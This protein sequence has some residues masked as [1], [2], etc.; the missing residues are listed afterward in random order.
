MVHVRTSTVSFVLNWGF[1]VAFLVQRFIEMRNGC[2]LQSLV[3]LVFISFYER[4]GGPVAMPLLVHSWSLEIRAALSSPLLIPHLIGRNPFRLQHWAV[5]F[6]LVAFL[7]WVRFLWP[8]FRIIHQFFF[9]RHFFT[10]IGRFATVCEIL[11]ALNELLS[12]KVCFICYAR[13]NG[14]LRLCIVWTLADA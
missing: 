2:L 5:Q 6:G 11:N 14:H 9:K 4:V 12:F 13:V 1:L 10:R 7:R 8:I 3:S